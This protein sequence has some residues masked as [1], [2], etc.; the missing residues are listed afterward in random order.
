MGKC[1]LELNES[2]LDKLFFE[3][4][5]MAASRRGHGDEAFTPLTIILMSPQYWNG[6]IRHKAF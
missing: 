6:A 3:Q 2:T 5:N 4:G 1:S